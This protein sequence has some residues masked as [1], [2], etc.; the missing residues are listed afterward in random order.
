MF[1]GGIVHGSYT[2]SLQQE[3]NQATPEMLQ[4]T[5][6]SVYTREFDLWYSWWY[7]TPA[8]AINPVPF[9]F[10][11]TQLQSLP[12]GSPFV[13]QFTGTVIH[14][15]SVPNDLDQFQTLSI[16]IGPF[17]FSLAVFLFLL[18]LWVRRRKIKKEFIKGCNDVLIRCGLINNSKNKNDRGSAE[19]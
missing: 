19:A 3:V 2:R 8:A 1:C 9:C 11:P 18:L 7:S 13:N 12:A 4:Q 5:L 15:S 6:D 14:D 10:R 17:F 16:A